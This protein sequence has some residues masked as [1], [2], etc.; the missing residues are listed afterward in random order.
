[1]RK[2]TAWKIAKAW[3]QAAGLSPEA[4]YAQ[5]IVEDTSDEG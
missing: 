1:M 2:P 5:I 3:A 4:A